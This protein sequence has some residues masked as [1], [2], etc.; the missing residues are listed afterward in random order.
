MEQGSD[1]GQ[2]DAAP[3]R[4]NKAQEA[5]MSLHPPARLSEGC[6]EQNPGGKTLP[7]RRNPKVCSLHTGEETHLKL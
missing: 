4:K 6:R 3:A 1:T 7:K 5:N 2:G